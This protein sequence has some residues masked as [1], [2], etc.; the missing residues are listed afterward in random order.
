MI[1][2]QAFFFLI[3]ISLYTTIISPQSTINPKDFQLDLE[4]KKTNLYYLTNEKGVEISLTNYGGIIVSIMIPNKLNQYENIIQSYPTLKEYISAQKKGIK[5]NSLLGRYSN[6]IEND[7]FTLNNKVYKLKKNY[8]NNFGEKVWTAVQINEKEIRMF[9]TSEDG[10]EGFPGK[11]HIEVIYT[12]TNNNELI[13]S[14]TG[15][16]TKTTV[17]NLSQRL[18]INLSG[19]SSLKEHILELNSKFY[20]PYDENNI[21][22]CDI[23]SVDNTIYDYKK[24]E[25]IGE[26]KIENYFIINGININNY[27]AKLEDKKSGRMMQIYTTEPGLDIYTIG[28]KISIEPKHFP[29]SPNVGFFPST[30]LNPGNIYTQKTIYKFAVINN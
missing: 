7:E 15:I 25:K 18:L 26:Q 10:E 19:N 11:L 3:S 28:N 30:L 9:L 5:I 14:Y 23:K 21:P 8:N 29:N 17:I 4:G 12:L 16:S 6:K 2:I 27:S 20:L 1:K 24:G 13:I 22:L